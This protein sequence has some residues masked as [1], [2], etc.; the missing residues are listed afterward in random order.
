ML[1][2][3]VHTCIMFVYNFSTLYGICRVNCKILDIDTR[4]HMCKKTDPKCCLVQSKIYVL[5]LP[6]YIKFGKNFFKSASRVNKYNNKYFCPP[7]NP[8]VNL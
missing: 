5:H 2:C 6:S 1:M 7:M 3:I 4:E 8:R